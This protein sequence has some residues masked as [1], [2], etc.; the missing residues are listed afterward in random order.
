MEWKLCYSRMAL[1]CFH[2]IPSFR[3]LESPSESE[4]LPPRP[5]SLPC[6]S[7]ANVDF[8]CMPSPSSRRMRRRGEDRRDRDSSASTAVDA[9]RFIISRSPHRPRRLRPARRSGISSRMSGRRV[10]SIKFI[11]L[12]VMSLV[13]FC[14]SSVT[15]VHTP[16]NCRYI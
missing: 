4:L 16:H 9:L 2:E 10:S 14:P 5:S 3:H 15:S 7:R 12:R 11:W 1:R 13:S 6:F 8:Q